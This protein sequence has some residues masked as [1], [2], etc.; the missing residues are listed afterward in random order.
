[1]NKQ[2]L[3][4]ERAARIEK[5][6]NLEPVD[7]IPVV[8]AGDAFAPRYMGL[9]LA[10]YCADPEAALQVA[11]RTMERLGDLD[12]ANQISCGR[13]GLGL[14]SLW[15]SHV[16]VP[17]RELPED[18]L[19]Q[20]QEAEVM[21]VEDY[22]FII[23]KGWPAF[24]TSYL[25]KV[26]DVAELEENEAWVAA[27]ARRCVES[28]RE[29]GYAVV[30]FGG[31]STPFEFLSGGRSMQQFFLDLHRR[32][33]RVQAAMDI[34]MPEII[35]AAIA[36]GR[37]SGVP[38]IWVGGW[39]AASSILAPRLWDKL[40]F[41][42][43]YQIVTALSEHGIISVLHL[44]QDWTR[45]LAR[46]RELPAKKCILNIDGMTDIRK[47]KQVLGDHMAIMGDVP[48][49]LFSA[50][51]PKGIRKYVQDLVRDI[52]PVGLILCPGCDAPVDTKPENMEVFVAAGREFGAG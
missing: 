27:N 20:V 13:I 11:L 14:S 31:T 7:R 38:R 50:G 28:A 24:L 51:T 19:W 4:Q 17:G 9:S 10:Q 40:V 21:S 6:I 52:G 39:R 33:D 30:S 5:A 42:Y 41:P 34:M 15:L 23:D 8:F 2:S 1:M 18:S 22:D 46:L 26:L 43:L 36:E 44:D 35:E 25:P 49:A 45:D 37:L 32:P 48:A 12:G 3:Y 16:A 29:L 47:A